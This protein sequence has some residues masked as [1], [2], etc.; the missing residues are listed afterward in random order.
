MENTKMR[1]SKPSKPSSIMLARHMP[2]S[3]GRKRS[4]FC[5]IRGFQGNHKNAPD[6]GNQA[7][8]QE[9]FGDQQMRADGYSDGVQNLYQHRHDQQFG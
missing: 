2:A 3:S 8:Y 9:R 5:E 1:M 7:H 4:S 6:R